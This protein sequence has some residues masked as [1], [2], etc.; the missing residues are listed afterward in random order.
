MRVFYQLWHQ[1]LMTINGEHLIAQAVT[2]CGGVNPFAALPALTPGS[3]SLSGSSGLASSFFTSFAG[4][5][6]A[7]G[8]SFFGSA[9]FIF[10]MRQFFKG[11][12]RDLV[13]AAKVDG[14][15][16]SENSFVVDG[17]DVSDVRRG[18]LRAQAAI[19]LEFIQEV[20]VKSGGF[21]ADIIREF[22]YIKEG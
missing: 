14:A 3:S 5:A 18:S 16:G 15:S 8:A 19:P 21:E 6:A 17:V 11:L 7:A 10:L 20:Q 2:A 1:P 4:S 13:D 9:F 12:P 22:V